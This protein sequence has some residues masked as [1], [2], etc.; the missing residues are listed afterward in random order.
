VTENH[1]LRVNAA[2][3]ESAFRQAVQD[4][5]AGILAEKQGRTLIDIAETI[6]VSVKTIS[7]AFNREH[8]LSW[9]FV[10]RMGKRFGA[11]HIDPVMALAGC[12]TTPIQP[13][14]RRDVLPFL[15]RAAAKIADA[16]DRDGPG[17]EHEIHSERFGYVKDLR[18]VVREAGALITEIDAERAKVRAA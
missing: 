18:D 16:R 8:S 10:L 1:V 3:E 15:T 14:G 12:R 5:I 9:M 13:S 7:N 11:H 2:E 17:G 4:T 6:D